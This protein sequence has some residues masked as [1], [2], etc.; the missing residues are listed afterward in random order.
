MPQ[1]HFP[2]LFFNHNYRLDFLNEWLEISLHPALR[3]RTLSADAPGSL[4]LNSCLG[5][6]TAQG[7]FGFI[8][9]YQ[10]IYRFKSR[11]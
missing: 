2:L 5:N 4:N 7:I 3:Y 10:W 8:A 6:S 9:S 1:H 11:R